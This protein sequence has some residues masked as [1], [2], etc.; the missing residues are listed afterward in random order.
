MGSARILETWSRTLLDLRPDFSFEFSHLFYEVEFFVFNYLSGH[1]DAVKS[2]CR[3]MITYLTK[4]YDNFEN[5]KNNEEFTVK[6]FLERFMSKPTHVKWVG[7]CWIAR[8]S[9]KSICLLEMENELPLQL[10]LTERAFKNS[11]N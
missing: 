1:I 7:L 9:P 4:L 11:V 5:F 10:L 8:S 6:K 3:N 2:C